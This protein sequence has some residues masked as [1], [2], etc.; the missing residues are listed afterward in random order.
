[1]PRRHTLPGV[2]DPREKG[3]GAFLLRRG[4]ELLGRRLFD[5]AAIVHHA[6][7]VLLQARDSIE[8]I[9]LRAT[10]LK[11]IRRGEVIAETAPVGTELRLGSDVTVE[12]FFWPKT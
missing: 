5:N 10:R 12:N 1:M 4:E 6:D 7:L 8:A 3:S 9:R 2:D 11:V